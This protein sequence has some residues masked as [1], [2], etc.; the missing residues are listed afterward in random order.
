MIYFATPC[1]RGTKEMIGAIAN[2]AAKITSDLA[3]KGAQCG[4]V[5][6]CPWLDAARADLIA[7]FLNTDC[8]YLFFQDD[9]I[10]IESNIIKRMLDMDRD[11][12]VAPY[13]MRLPP[14]SWA[15]TQ[16]NGQTIN[17]GLGCALI[18]RSVVDKMIQDYPE[19]TYD[20]DG[21]ERVGLFHHIILN[22]N[23]LKEDH[24]FFYRALKSGFRINCLDNAT[25]DHAGVIS[26]WKN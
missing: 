3:I 19:L 1:H 11:I 6:N 17:A 14:H 12:V 10:S 24:A 20:Q 9:D 4:I 26:T 16:N 23:M 25:V 5:T 7:G 2:K 18:R 8:K 13:K 21:Q 15:I 22:K